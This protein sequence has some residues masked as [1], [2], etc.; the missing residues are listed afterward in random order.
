[1]STNSSR[2]QWHISSS[3][4]A[5]VVLATSKNWLKVST[6]KISMKV[7]LASLCSWIAVSYYCHGTSN[8]AKLA[9]PRS[10]CKSML[11]RSDSCSWRN[12]PLSKWKPKRG[13]SLP[14]TLYTGSKRISSSLELIF[15]VPNQRST[16]SMDSCSSVYNCVV[17]CSYFDWNPS[18]GLMNLWSFLS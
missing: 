18:R 14:C 1:M 5:F 3:I 6:T 4:A 12:S 8:S 16:G 9:S 11:G 13:I 10:T 17:L 15:G 7:S 2:L